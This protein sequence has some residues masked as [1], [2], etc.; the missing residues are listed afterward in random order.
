MFDKIRI[1]ILAASPWSCSRIL[2]DEEAREIFVRLQE[3]PFR[4][5]FEVRTHMAVKPRDLQQLLMLYR[6]HIVHFSGHGHKTRQIILGGICG[7]GRTVD[8]QGLA[9][10]FALYRHHVRLVVLNAC[11]TDTLAHSIVKAVDYSIGTTKAIGDK[12]A[13]AFA[14]AFYRALGFGNSVREAFAS[15]KVEL[16][17]TKVPRAQGFELFL[18]NGINECD[19]FPD[20]NNNMPA[21]K[22]DALKRRVASGYV[23]SVRRLRRRRFERK[24]TNMALTNLKQTIGQASTETRTTLR[25]PTSKT[26]GTRIGILELWRGSSNG[27]GPGRCGKTVRDGR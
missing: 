24:E 21:R 4:D 2:V 11:L 9:K 7:R 18:R 25:K 13:V 26:P 23:N 15:A 3:G 10:L 22:R 5:R 6:P 27:K 19:S 14:G 16:G 1:L 12:A 20:V 17:L 8:N